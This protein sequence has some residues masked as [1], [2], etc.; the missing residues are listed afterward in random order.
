MTFVTGW[1][2]VAG[3]VAASIPILIHILLRRRRK[4]IQWA[5]MALLME[6]SRRQQRRARLEQIILLALRCL[7]LLVAGLALAQPLLS[8]IAGSGRSKIVHIILDDGI[9]SGLM[10]SEGR[11]A[12]EQQVEGARQDI[13]QLDPGDRLTVVLAGRP[14][15][16][17]IDEPTS[18]HQ[19][20][21][22]AIE[23]LDSR[24]GAT[25]YASALDLL[26][27]QLQK[28]GFDHE[29]RL[30]GDFRAGSV[31]TEDQLPKLEVVE[32]STLTLAASKPV[33]TPAGNVQVEAIEIARNPASTGSSGNSGLVQVSVRLRRNGTMPAGRTTV[34]LEGDAIDPVSSRQVEWTPGREDAVVEFQARVDDDGGV[35]QAVID[36]DDLPADNR[37]LVSVEPAGP[38]RVLMVDRSD[39]PGEVRL[40][41]LGVSDWVERALDPIDEGGGLSS[42]VRV[43]RTDP[44]TLDPRDLEDTTILVLARPDLVDPNL[45][46]AIARFANNGGVVVLVPPTNEVARPWASPILTAMDVPWS[47]SLEPDVLDESRV[48]ATRQPDSN[49]LRLLSGELPTLAPAVTIDQRMLVDN[50]DDADAVL[51]D[52]EGDPVVLVSPVGAGRLIFFATAPVLEWTDLP[53]K[54]LMV[55]LIH[56]IARQG[57]ALARRSVD[58]VVGERFP[59]VRSPAAVALLDG[60]GRRIPH[61]SGGSSPALLE[62]SGSFTVIDLADNPIETV[63]VNPAIGAAMVEPSGEVEVRDWLGQLGDIEI[64]SESEQVA[65]STGPRGNDFAFQL[66]IILVALVILETIAAKYF[67]R[68]SLRRRSTASMQSTR[69]PGGQDIMGST[70]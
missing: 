37:R 21:I 46:P 65:D 58:G 35:L 28:P 29:V 31:R 69:V 17:L 41:R 30:L 11:T 36:P 14:A 70:T 6:A 43:E 2:A 12:L 38:I 42:A 67:S 68:G 54:P 45:Y 10:D 50:W 34:R 39:L 44:V 63:V 15:R 7:I 48:L 66:L 24:D 59:L 19:S 53:V 33:D 60:G 62:K 57:S 56:E 61:E 51:V 9:V 20:V 18:D 52:G 13:E 55:P 16:L 49:L 4:P 32:G 26:A 40:D 5:A 64:L 8:N 22:R 3:L 47:V 25:D 27:P 23:D 1:I